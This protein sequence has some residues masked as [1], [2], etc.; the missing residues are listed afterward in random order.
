MRTTSG[1]NLSQTETKRNFP[2]NTAEEA[3]NSRENIRSWRTPERDK[4]DAI[5]GEKGANSKG[6]QGLRREENQNCKN[7]EDK[8]IAASQTQSK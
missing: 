8:E 4:W 7:E 1:E 6:N 3:E 5:G 2:V